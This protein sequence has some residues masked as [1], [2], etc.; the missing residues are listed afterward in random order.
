MLR[1]VLALSVAMA[2]GLTTLLGVPLFDGAGAVWVFFAI[3]GFLITIALERKYGTSGGGLRHFYWNRVIRL[4]PAYW[5]YL[6]LFILLMA[7]FPVAFTHRTSPFLGF[8]GEMLGTASPVTLGLAFF[9]NATG[10][11][12]DSFLRLVVD[13]ASGR[14][15]EGTASPATPWAMTFIL[16][17]QYW[18][19]GVEL[20]FYALAPLLVRRVWAVTLV[21]MLSASG[22]MEAWW[23]EGTRALGLHP[24]IVQLQAPKFLW[25]FMAGAVLAHLYFRWQARDRVAG[26]AL[27]A[28]ALGMAAMLWWRQGVL[29]PMQ[30][31]P[32]WV[33]CLLVTAVPVLFHL[34][35]RNRID[36]FIGDLSYPVY[37]NHFVLTQMMG[38]LFFPPPGWLI[39]VTSVALAAVTVLL[40]ERPAQAWKWGGRG[41]AV[42]TAGERRRA[43]ADVSPA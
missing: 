27:A 26:G 22:L 29:F 18:S 43:K 39:A 33:F 42:P 28:A 11:F 6:L 7:A 41:L 30:A 13:P 3:S 1:L 23:I 35:S 4:Y 12:A 20:V 32:W 9:S 2:H 5:V 19:I 16:I 15:I 38:S 17:G 24:A 10:F 40:V 36:R 25:T 14:L 31:F 37:L 21:F 34:T 8:W